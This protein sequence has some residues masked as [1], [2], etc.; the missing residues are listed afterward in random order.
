MIDGG[1]ARLTLGVG[2]IGILLALNPVLD[3]ARGP[4][5]GELLSSGTTRYRNWG[6][7]GGG[8]GISPRGQAIRGS[9]LLET[10]AGDEVVIEPMGAQANRMESWTRACPKG[11]RV[12][13]LRHLDV[14]LDV[15]CPQ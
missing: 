9:M 3:P 13:A 8:A 12:R 2:A 4:V 10:D 7:R 1:H 6:R 14:V 11:G 5:E 15:D